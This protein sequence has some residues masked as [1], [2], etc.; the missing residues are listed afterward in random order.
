MTASGS[1][2][3]RSA[4]H[5]TAPSRC[6]RSTITTEA[7]KVY[8]QLR[9]EW[10]FHR[11]SEITS[12]TK[13]L[14]FPWFP[15]GTNSQWYAIFGYAL[16]TLGVDTASVTV[17]FVG[18]RQMGGGIHSASLYGP[19]VQEF[20]LDHGET[21]LVLGT[22]YSGGTVGTRIFGRHIEGVNYPIVQLGATS[23]SWFMGDGSGI[24]NLDGMF[25][26]NS[27]TFPTTA[28]TY[29]TLFGGRIRV[30]GFEYDFTNRNKVNARVF[31]T[32]GGGTTDDTDAIQGA[33]TA[34]GNAGGGE[35]YLGAGSFKISDT[36]TMASQ[37]VTLR[38]D[39][40]FATR[41]EMQNLPLPYI[42]VTAAHC[43]INDLSTHYNGTPV[44]G[45]S[46]IYA[47]GTNY[48]Y[49]SGVMVRNAFDGFQL[50]GMSNS[51]L[52]NIIALNYENTGI[53]CRDVC[54]DV[55]VDQFYLNCGDTT[56]GDLGGIRLYNQCE[57][58]VFTNGEVLQGG[59]SMTIAAAANTAGNRPA[60][61][62]FTN[63]YFD[64]AT[65]GVNVNS[66]VELT[67]NDCWFSN[68]PN[69]GISLSNTDGVRFTGGGAMNCGTHG[70][71][72]NATAV[73]T[74]FTNF[75]ARGNSQASANVSSG[76]AFAPNT[77]DFIVQG[78]TLG[79]SLGFGSQKYG[80]FV[81]VGT[82]DRYI[83][84]DNLVT[85]NTTGGVSDGG[86]GANKRV[87]NNY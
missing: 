54:L 69:H 23:S 85:G 13:F 16:K 48:F 66:A 83:V 15:N 31:G 35:V 64:S 71:L 1:R 56:R 76:I 8:T 73:R 44:A 61:C 50:V 34:V 30:S 14:A 41:L 67:F 47:S 9:S 43:H 10:S 87:A 2:S 7:A 55:Y 12:G 45:A 51:F 37:A 28:R 20:L 74:T 52:N 3:S 77:T 40:H 58:V 80:V 42:S 53:Y 78:C 79:G 70:V 72:V 18:G 21:G 68:R 65:N 4:A 26:L 17:D 33:I 11:V 19:N 25:L 36:L 63:I 38:G 75:S 6:V 29:G 5:P 60:Y 39:G 82:S 24:T 86:S 22:E 81:D 62:K 46:G 49:A 59:Y 57:A 84:S 27:R 32:V